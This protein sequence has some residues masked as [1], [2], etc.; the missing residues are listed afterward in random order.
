MVVIM[1][2][3]TK[4]CKSC[5]TFNFPRPLNRFNV[6]RSSYIENN[7]GR[8][9]LQVPKKKLKLFLQRVGGY[10][11]LTLQL[12]CLLH[13]LY[14]PFEHICKLLFNLCVKQALIQATNLENIP[15]GPANFKSSLI[16]IEC[17][18]SMSLLLIMI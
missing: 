1:L 14:I 10:L 11:T 17:S 5:F 2:T 12:L 15:D 6:S 13:L 18:F 9:R 7:F 8:W 4:D 16:F 3:V